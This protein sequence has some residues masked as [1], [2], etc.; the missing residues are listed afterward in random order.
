M[1]VFRA[2]GF[3]SALTLSVGAAAAQ[4]TTD[5]VTTQYSAPARAIQAQSEVAPVAPPPGTLATTREHHAVDAYGNRVDSSSSTYRNDQG[6][7]ED[8][9]MTT[10]SVPAPPP[11][12]STTTTTTRS[13]TVAPN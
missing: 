2:A 4:T 5:T 3:A 13:T 10:T 7:A 8:R 9:T 6:V 1:N 11:V 12:A